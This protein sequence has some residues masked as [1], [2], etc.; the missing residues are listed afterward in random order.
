LA[1]FQL[2]ESNVE[3][4]ELSADPSAAAK[5]RA[6]LRAR[7]SDWSSDGVEAVQLLVSEL[8]TNAV[9]HTNDPVEVTAVRSGSRVTVEVTDRNP[10]KPVLKTY[11]RDAATGRGLR[12]VESLADEWGV[13]GDENRK[14]VW[15]RVVDGAP[16]P[17]AAGPRRRARERPT[18]WCRCP[19]TC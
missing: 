3:R 1:G 8:V 9:L 15:F 18:R 17:A 6:W 7:L 11:G 13:R 4:L 16:S 5:A 12:L 2:A 10:S 14:A 19:W